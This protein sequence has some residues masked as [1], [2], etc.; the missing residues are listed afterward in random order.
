MRLVGLRDAAIENK[1]FLENHAL[2]MEG[3]TR[4][5]K[6]KWH[7]FSTQAENDAKDG[8]DFS[9]AKH[10]CMEV[11]LQQWSVFAIGVFKTRSL[12]LHLI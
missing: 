12:Q 11:F 2:R 7:T 1:S 4:E 3:V 10:S 8:A 6:R 9:A 5:A